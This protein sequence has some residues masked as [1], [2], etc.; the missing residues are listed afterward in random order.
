MWQDSS[1]PGEVGARST[2][3][4]V[5]FGV[6]HQSVTL[7]H[8]FCT[9]VLSGN[10]IRQS[11]SRWRSVKESKG[12]CFGRLEGLDGLTGWLT[13]LAAMPDDMADAG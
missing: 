5:L 1:R 2:A 3:N 9:V 11:A 7:S 6:Q 8:R 13:A 10:H 12:L 4:R